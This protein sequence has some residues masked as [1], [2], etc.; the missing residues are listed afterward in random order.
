MR[1]EHRGA[2]QRRHQ[3]AH[4][5]ER[6]RQAGRIHEAAQSNEGREARGRP[7]AKDHRGRLEGVGGELVD[8]V[9]AQP[10]IDRGGRRWCV[11]QARRKRRASAHLSVA[12]AER[13]LRAPLCRRHGLEGVLA[14]ELVG[15]PRAYTHTHGCALVHPVRERARPQV[16]TTA[17][18]RPPREL[19]AEVAFVVLAVE[20]EAHCIRRVGEVRRACNHCNRHNDRYERDEAAHHRRGPAGSGGQ[21]GFIHSEEIGKK[22]M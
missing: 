19:T 9:C 15:E 17:A 11:R 20:A 7:A 10:A 14:D 22:A 2:G 8:R 21:A 18:A 5:R 13:Q 3:R 4:H 16:A 1:E 6:Q 12:A